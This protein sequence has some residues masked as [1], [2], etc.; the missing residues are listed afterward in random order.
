MG[1]QIEQFIRLFFDG[2][3][4]GAN[5]GRALT[6]FTGTNVELSL[7]IR[8]LLARLPLFAEKHR[9]LLSQTGRFVQCLHMGFV[10]PSLKF[11]FEF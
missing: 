5:F 11:L 3:V 10:Q 2:V 8:Y 7:Q 1:L 4:G 6:Q 9:L